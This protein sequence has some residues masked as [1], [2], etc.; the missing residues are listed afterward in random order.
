MDLGSDLA[1]LDGIVNKR[2]FLGN[3]VLYEI[4]VRQQTLVVD[5]VYGQGR[6]LVDRGEKTG[7]QVNS[8]RIVVMG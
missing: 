3:L 8:G 1:D 6:K 7:L 2:E 5:E 4:Q